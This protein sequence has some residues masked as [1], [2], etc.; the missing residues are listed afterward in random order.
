M[1]MTL[2]SDTSILVCLLQSLLIAA[3]LNPAKKSK[4]PVFSVTISSFTLTDNT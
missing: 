1:I 2:D 4:Y 3:L